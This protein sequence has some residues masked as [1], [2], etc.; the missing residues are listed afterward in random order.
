MGHMPARQRREGFTG[1]ILR[2]NTPPLTRGWSKV[3]TI[4]PET[5]R[6][7]GF[8]YAQVFGFFFFTEGMTMQDP[9]QSPSATTTDDVLLELIRLREQDAIDRARMEEELRREIAALWL[10]LHQ[11]RRPT[12]SLPS[13][14]SRNGKAS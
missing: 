4:P 11:L 5:D 8:L 7:P 1:A 12:F 10:R 13:I 6:F 3:Q 14:F 2:L 9:F